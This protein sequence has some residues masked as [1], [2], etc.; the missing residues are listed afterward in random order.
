MVRGGGSSEFP[1]AAKEGTGEN[2]WMLGRAKEPV[3]PLLG[4]GELQETA[5]VGAGEVLGEP[6]S[7]AGVS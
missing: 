7:C 5:G 3:G 6:R 4:T 1:E 2:C